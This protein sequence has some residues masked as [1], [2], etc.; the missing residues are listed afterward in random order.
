MHTY[1]HIYIHCWLRTGRLKL[2][3]LNSWRRVLSDEAIIAK[4]KEQ[5]D[6]MIGS[7]C[8]AASVVDAAIVRL[9]NAVNNY[10]PG[11]YKDLP[12][13]ASVIAQHAYV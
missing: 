11:S 6:R 12:D 4:A 5:L 9:P 13:L 1:M 2:S 8:A 7:S 10:F 3:E